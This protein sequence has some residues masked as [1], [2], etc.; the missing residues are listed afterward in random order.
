[1][2][3]PLPRLG[4]G[5]KATQRVKGPDGQN[6]VQNVNNEWLVKDEAIFRCRY[7]LSSIPLPNCGFLGGKE[8]TI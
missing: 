6:G 1:M 3:I 8:V 5:R 2:M 7:N 4:R